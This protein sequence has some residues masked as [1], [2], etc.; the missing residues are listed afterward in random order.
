MKKGLAHIRKEVK[1]LNVDIASDKRYIKDQPKKKSEMSLSG[2]WA[3][4]RLSQ[5]QKLLD[6]F[7]LIIEKIK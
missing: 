7:K 3:L 6:S 1:R 2:R 4:L 5:N